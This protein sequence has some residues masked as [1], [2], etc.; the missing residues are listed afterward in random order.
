MSTSTYTRE[1][2]EPIV[3]SSFSV[4]EVMRH[5]CIKISGG[6]HRYWSF[7][8]RKK[9]SIDT[10]HFQ[11]NRRQSDKSKRHHSTV[12]I[13]NKIG[14]TKKE[15]SKLRRAF[16]EAGA[17]YRCARCSNDGTWQGV[18][19]T[20]E[21]DHINGN[22]IDNRYDNLQFLCPNCHSLKC[23]IEYI[24]R[25]KPKRAP[26]PRRPNRKVSWPS[27][28]ELSQMLLAEPMTSIASRYGVTSVAVAKWCK[29][30]G[31]SRPPRGYW[32]KRRLGISHDEA[33]RQV[34]EVAGLK[35]ASAD[36]GV[37]ETPEFINSST[38]Q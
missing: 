27:K 21:I 17:V 37:S 19:M 15:T 6:N 8:I 36:A 34:A 14:T 13:L 11:P 9:F 32:V 3:K 25:R 22:H 26:V 20:L 18:S 16:L 30:Y 35:P 31:L 38:P 29:R 28:E 10:S 1:L 23:A 7:L 5:F 4:T 24:Q 33:L 12:L 2:I